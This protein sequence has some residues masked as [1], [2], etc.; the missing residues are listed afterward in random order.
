MMSKIPPEQSWLF[1]TPALPSLS[2]PVTLVRS[3]RK[4]WSISIEP[5]L[6]I[7]MKVPLSV[8]GLRAKQ[9][10]SSK[11]SW[12]IKKYKEL[13]KIRED[14]PVSDLTPIQEKALEQRYRQAAREYFPSRVAY[15]EQIIGVTHASIRIRDQKTRWGS[16][17][18]KG[19]LNFN[20]RLML[21]PPRVL[22][23][24]VVHELCHRKEMNH[25]KAFWDAVGTVLP[26][27]VQLR[28][29]LK[30]N[31]RKLTLSSDHSSLQSSAES[32]S[33]VYSRLE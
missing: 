13:K 29:W 16:C 23:Y 28:K 18:A 20:W 9:I 12:I 14:M 27:Y 2:I 4:T 7:V 10:L 5:D 21:A 11:E 22:D 32:L 8:S 6:T 26:D 1:T 19:N 17:S 24:V 33:P 30:D 15:Y 31:G 25:S 3:R